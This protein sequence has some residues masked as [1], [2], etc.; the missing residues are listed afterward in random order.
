MSWLD[1]VRVTPVEGVST[2]ELAAAVALHYRYRFDPKGLTPEERD[3][4]RAKVQAWLDQQ[5]TARA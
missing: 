2:A 3:T 4:L 1:R 5:A